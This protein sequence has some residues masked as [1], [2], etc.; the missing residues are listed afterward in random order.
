MVFNTHQTYIHI[1]IYAYAYKFKYNVI[2]MAVAQH[3]ASPTQL[4]TSFPLA[5]NLLNFLCLNTRGR[6]GAATL[7]SKCSNVKM[8]EQSLPIAT[9]ELIAK[10]GNR[11]SVLSTEKNRTRRTVKGSVI[12]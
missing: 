10:P 2:T 7:N 4:N 8:N 1:S 12:N 3:N 5:S 11:A 9:I 6:V